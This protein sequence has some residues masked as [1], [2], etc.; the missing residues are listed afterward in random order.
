MIDMYR[1]ILSLLSR[2]ERRRLYLLLSL[3]IIRGP[4]EVVGIVSIMPFLAVAANPEIIENNAFLAAAFD[5]LGFSSTTAFLQALGV[6][7]MLILLTRIIFEALTRYA[8]IRFSNMRSFSLSQRLLSVYL[9]QPYQWFLNR[10]SADIMKSVLGEVMS[11]VSGVLMPSLTLFSSI[12]A[13]AFVVILVIIIDPIV[14]I[15][16]TFFVS[17]FYGLIYFF[18]RR[19]IPRIGADRLKANQERTMLTL[20]ATGGI[21][22]VKVLGLEAGYLRRF[23]DPAYRFSVHQANYQI[24]SAM[25]AFGL[26][27]ILYVGGMLLVLTLLT[28]RDGNLNAVLPQIGVYILAG[29]RLMA[30]IGPI[31]KSLNSIR[32][33]KP[34]LDTI[35][36]DLSGWSDRPKAVVRDTLAPLPLHEKLLL[37]DVTFTYPSAEQP[38]LRGLSMTIP[39]NSTV[40]L[41]GATGAGKTTVVDLIL[42]LLLPQQGHLI[43]DGAPITAEKVPAWQKSVGYVSQHIF[44][45][46]DTISANIAFGADPAQIDAETVERCARIANLHDFVMAEMPQGYQTMVGERGVRLSGG[47][48]QRIG[49]ARALYHDP[50]VLVLDE[51]TSA[52]DNIT[53][54]AV[55][56]AV[57]NLSGRKTI[58]M[59]AHRLST[60][61]HCDKIFLMER[62]RVTAAGSYDELFANNAN[63]RSMASAG[64]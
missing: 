51:A 32:F 28:L 45:V 19:F 29:Q 62:G 7:V 10:H 57:G 44:L 20:E 55:M 9:S 35:Y 27:A 3:L 60:V 12:L 5:A 22:D 15:A 50:D 52:L 46:D 16:S 43:V 2:S 40:G 18:T 58:I 8:I 1:K 41:V 42:G 36:P 53:E 34:A 4:V 49:I 31:F 25:P 48:R 47:Q 61:R 63:F 38:A 59:I 37:D 33:N 21:K 6:A 24:V 54:R 13:G 64:T 39:A 56:D 11:V 14:A 26:Q 23:R 30:A 17:V